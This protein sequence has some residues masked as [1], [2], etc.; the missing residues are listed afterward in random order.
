MTV[1]DRGTV[2][3]GVVSVHGRD[4]LVLTG[5]V[6][7]L[8][9]DVE[10]TLRSAAGVRDCAVLALPHERLGEVVAAVVVGGD[11]DEVVAHCRDRLPREQRPVRWFTADRLPSTPGGKLDAAAL[12]IAIAA[13]EVRR[14]R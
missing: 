2:T 5:G 3:D 13:E 12:R 10:A 6:S 8:V 4:G 1:G 14:W 9:A 11:R 7:V